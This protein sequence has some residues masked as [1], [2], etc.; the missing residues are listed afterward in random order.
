MMSCRVC[1]PLRTLPLPVKSIQRP[2]GRSSRT[3]PR[4]D[5]TDRFLDALRDYRR[6]CEDYTW[7][8]SV[9]YPTVIFYD[10]NEDLDIAN[11]WTVKGQAKVSTLVNPG[12]RTMVAPRIYLIV[13]EPVMRMSTS[14]L[15]LCCQSGP[16]AT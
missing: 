10:G 8:R 2:S 6:F 12:R 14:L 13:R 5:E 1:S 16:D 11:Y 4:L 7:D 15:A 9:A 3:V